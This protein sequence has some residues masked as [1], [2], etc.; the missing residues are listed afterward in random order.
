MITTGSLQAISLIGKIYLDPGDVA[1]VENPCF[2]GAISA[3]KSY[4]AELVGMPMDADGV[5]VADLRHALSQHKDKCKV[6]YLTPNFHNPAGLIY[7]RQRRQE[8]LAALHGHDVILLEDDAYSE[9]YF[10]ESDRDLTRPL[11]TMGPEPVAMCYCGSF[12]KIFGPGMRLGW[13]LGPEEIIRQ[14]EVAKQSIDACAPT[15]TQMLANEFLVQEKLVEYLQRIRPIY[16]RR[17]HLLLDHLQKHMPEG[18]TWN[19]P[20]GGFYIWVKLPPG[21]DAGEVLTRSAAQGAIFVVGK[22]FDPQGVVND[23][24][25]LS[26]CHMPEEKMEQGVRIIAEAIKK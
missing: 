21:M 17:C 1:L 12:S 23:H 2:I 5:I 11:K 26:F 15:F 9:L 14:C 7:S 20:L 8:V 4:Q 3:F 16:R 25:R 24:I 18:V 13:L 19:V 22:T 10:A 6:V